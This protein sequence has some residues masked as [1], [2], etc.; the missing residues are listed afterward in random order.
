MTTPTTK[1]GAPALTDFYDVDSL[2]SPE[3]R[4]IQGSV[5]E[6]VRSELL[7]HVGGWWQDGEFPPEL[8]RRFGDLGA[9]ASNWQQSAL[10]SGGDFDYN[11]TVNVGDLGILATNW[12]QGVTTPTLGPSFSEAL[13][14]LGLGSVAVPEPA[15]LGALSLAGLLALRRRSR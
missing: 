8:A 15:S 13:A 5:R 10:W 4:L 14:A 12:Q 1:A 6:Y 7:P 3:E 2:L 9:L 11:G